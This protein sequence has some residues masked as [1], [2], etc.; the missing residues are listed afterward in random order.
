[1]KIRPRKDIVAAMGFLCVSLLLAGAIWWAWRQYITTPPYVDAER[2]PV[3]G[4]DISAH[5]GYANLDAAA[6]AGFDFLFI[7]AS[8]GTD[9]RDPNFV[10]NWQKARHAGLKTGAYHFFRFDADGVEQANHFLKVIGP[11]TP[12]LPLVIDVE[13]AGN[14]KGVTVETV[15]ENLQQMVEYL[16]MRGYRVMLY[17]NRAG[18]EKY[19]L[20]NFPGYP[21]WVCSFN[22]N[23]S[24]SDWTFWQY[25][26]HG[27]VPGV[28]G[29]VDLNVFSGSR[30]DWAKY[31][32][33]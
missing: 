1:M 31:L 17:S 28:R 22:D 13:D 10:L 27:S 16:N 20:E 26:H 25:D 6:S 19:L 2:F 7:K 4:F 14:A 5:N 11:R 33:E 18:F 32:A 23:S 9:F 21:L 8:E 15:V 3:R 29:D 30:E 24:N 12:D